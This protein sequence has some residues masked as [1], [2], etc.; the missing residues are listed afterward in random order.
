MLPAAPFPCVSSQMTSPD[1]AHRGVPAAV[2]APDA[3]AA[4]AVSAAPHATAA[5]SRLEKARRDM[6]CP[7][8]LDGMTLGVDYERPSGPH[9]TARTPRPQAAALLGLRLARPGR[10]Q[11]RSAVCKTRRMRGARS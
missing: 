8:V 7:L 11:R 5:V 4:T 2:A 10:G 6:A 1:V 3:A 9:A